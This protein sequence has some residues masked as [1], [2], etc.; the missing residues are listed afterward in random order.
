MS[1]KPM[2]KKEWLAFLDKAISEFD[3]SAAHEQQPVDEPV[4]WWHFNKGFDHCM[5]DRL[6]EAAKQNPVPLYT[7]PQPAAWVGLTD[8]ETNALIP[9]PDG[10]AEADAKR[11][12]VLPGIWGSEFDEVDA[13][14][15]PLVLQVLRDYEAKLREKN[16]GKA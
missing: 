10:S 6:N 3:W 8:E 5:T 1:A 7:R 11:V 12:E 2:T 13:W 4:T 9:A 15:K 16:G 14:S